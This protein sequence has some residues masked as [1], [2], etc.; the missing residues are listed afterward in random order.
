MDT[1]SPEFRE[2]LA[3][4]SGK[5]TDNQVMNLIV[6]Q[7]RDSNIAAPSL[8]QIEVLQEP[9]TNLV[10]LVKEAAVLS[11]EGDLQTREATEQVIKAHIA[12]VL[13]ES[14]VDALQTWVIENVYAQRIRDERAFADYGFAAALLSDVA[15]ARSRA[16]L[17]PLPPNVHLA[18]IQEAIAL[19]N[20]LLAS[21]DVFVTPNT[22]RMMI[23]DFRTYA[24]SLAAFPDFR[25]AE[26]SNSDATKTLHSDF[27]AKYLSENPIESAEMTEREKSLTLQR[28]IA[29][30]VGVLGILGTYLLLRNRKPTFDEMQTVETEMLIDPLAIEQEEYAESN[31][32]RTDWSKV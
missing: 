25:H 12:K 26:L 14:L 28:N 5:V 24:R 2:A 21:Y 23:P 17:P 9:L 19:S 13:K 27:F 11:F 31:Y 22:P 1:N 15:Y 29:I 3:A 18:V 20:A 16:G 8:I 4:L 10:A 6:R 32:A 7:L 30:G